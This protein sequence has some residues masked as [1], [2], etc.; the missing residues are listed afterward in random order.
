[1]VTGVEGLAE[2]TR[3]TVTE[4]EEKSLGHVLWEFQYLRLGRRGWRQ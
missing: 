2:G 4:G 1:M 3:E